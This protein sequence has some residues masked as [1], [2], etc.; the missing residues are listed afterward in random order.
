MDTFTSILTKLHSFLPIHGYSHIYPNKIKFIVT[1]ILSHHPKQNYIHR[2]QI[3]DTLTSILTKLHSS[4][5]IHG[6]FQIY[7][8]MMIAISC[9]LFTN[10][11][12]IN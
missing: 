12:L 11:N 9:I 5:P 4:L 1:W 7:P 8:N 6:Y 2:Y 10:S 3:M